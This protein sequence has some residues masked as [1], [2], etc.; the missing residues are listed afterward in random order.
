MKPLR[1]AVLGATGR[2]G[3]T[4]VRLA[5]A[6]AGFQ[7]TQALTV[8]NDPLIGQDAGLI[9]GVE[10]LGVP[11]QSEW[12]G[13]S[14]AAIDFSS[15][16]GCIAAAEF[17]AR[18]GCP[19]VSGTTGLSTAQSE[20]LREAARRTAILWSPNMSVGVALLLKLVEQVAASLPDWDCEIVETHHVRKLD[21]PSGT[22]RAILEAASRARRV[23]AHAVARHG[24]APDSPPRRAGEIGV[25]ALRVGGVVGDH[26]V[27][28]GTPGETL[29][30]RHHAESRE[31]FA[32]GALRAARWIVGKPPAMYSMRDVLA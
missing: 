30:L 32:A 22:A 14:D 11:L 6:D 23:D 1:L 21:A 26:D 4:V 25:H 12:D 16:A 19:L 8:A 27:V 20:T 5:A 9:A 13:R 28:F 15:P 10:S 3:R 18:V 29:T 24:R 7:L 17:S 31:I 2:M